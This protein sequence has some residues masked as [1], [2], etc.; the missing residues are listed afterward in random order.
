MFSEFFLWPW[1]TFF[2]PKGAM[3]A[4][5]L[6]T[7]LARYYPYVHIHVRDHH[8]VYKHAHDPGHQFSSSELVISFMCIYCDLAVLLLER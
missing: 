4:C 1:M 2:W 5:T 8:A 3:A 7:L 6:N